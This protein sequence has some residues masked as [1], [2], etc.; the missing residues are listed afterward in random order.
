MKQ[1]STGRL[2]IPII[3]GLVNKVTILGA[4]TAIGNGDDDFEWMDNWQI[5]TKDAGAKAAGA[6][7]LPHLRGDVLLVSKSEAASALIYWNGKRYVWLQ[8]GD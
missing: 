2:G 5:Y 3:H 8:Q 4:E 1:R 6:Q 7:S